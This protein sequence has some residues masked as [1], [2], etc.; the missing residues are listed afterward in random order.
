MAARSSSY[1]PE[2][3]RALQAL[4]PVLG[5]RAAVIYEAHGRSLHKVVGF[6]R[7]S[8]RPGCRRLVTGLALAQAL[9]AEQLRSRCVFTSPAAVKDYL[10][11]HF[12]GQAHESFGVMFLD[13]QHALLDPGP[14]PRPFD[15]L[16]TLRGDLLSVPSFPAHGLRW[17]PLGGSRGMPCNGGTEGFDAF[18]VERKVAC[19]TARGPV[20]PLRQARCRPA[21]RPAPVLRLSFNAAT[22]SNASSVRPA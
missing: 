5:A 6:A 9:L 20:A 4:R 22:P 18:E 19:E 17:A 8:S 1:T 15:L 14:R 13:T 21:V 16:L 3:Q 2:Q 11:L 7:D 10:K 12:A